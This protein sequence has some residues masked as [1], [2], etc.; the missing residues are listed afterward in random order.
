M[1]HTQTSPWRLTGIQKVF[2]S[3]PS[4][5][6]DFLTWIYFSLS[7]P[8]NI[9][10]ECLL[11]PIVSPGKSVWLVSS[12]CDLF[13]YTSIVI[14]FEGATITAITT[15]MFVCVAYGYHVPFLTWNEG[16]TPLSNKSQ[17]TVYKKQVVESGANFVQSI[18]SAICS[19]E[20]RWCCTIISPVQ[21]TI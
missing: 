17:S 9:I 4:G 8:I 5:I 1:L 20:T 14:I 6:S 3:N 21:A 7:Q 11:S 19:L 2:D 10:H 18:L 15:G 12:L 16:R 13:S